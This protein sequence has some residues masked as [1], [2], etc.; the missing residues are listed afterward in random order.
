MLK[1][2]LHYNNIYI[3]FMIESIMASKSICITIPQFLYDQYFKEHSDNRSQFVVQYFMKGM[4]LAESNTETT[5]SRNVELQKEVQRLTQEL[6][7]Y[8]KEN[9]MLIAKY[10]N[11]HEM[12]PKQ[13][14]AKAIINRGLE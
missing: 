7:H 11:K 10:R 2:I 12:T 4:E 5:K 14:M 8:K 3:V 6:D 1:Y 13:K 9:F